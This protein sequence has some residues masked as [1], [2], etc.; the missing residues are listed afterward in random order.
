MEQRFGARLRHHREQQ[1]VTLAQICADTK[2]KPS[3]LESLE[4]DDVSQWPKGL[5]GRA[6]LRNYARAIGLDA[7]VVVS[8]FL[9]LH[10]GFA[11]GNP[12]LDEREALERSRST[13]RSNGRLRRA[14]N[15]FGPVRTLSAPVQVESSDPIRESAA[16]VIEQ[17]ALFAPAEQQPQTPESPLATP[18]PPASALTLFADICTQLARAVDWADLRA[19]LADAARVLDASGMILWQWDG[20]WCAL[21][22]AVAHGYPEALLAR[23]PAVGRDADNAVATAFRTGEPCVIDSA[24]RGVEALVLPAIGIR[25]CIGVLALEL[26]PGAPSR[27]CLGPLATILAAQ[28]AMLLPPEPSR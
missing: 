12:D 8:E 28:L 15:A 16:V 20:S 3:L 9:A 17:P 10:P 19:V 26:R 21:R 6:Y 4:S 13:Q 22:P 24:D 27:E 14:L 7:E 25:G 23:L 11:Q 2:I 1:G 5:F 18:P